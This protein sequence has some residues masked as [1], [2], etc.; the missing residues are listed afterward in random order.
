M[1]AFLL[2]L[3]LCA[4]ASA[5]LAYP[6]PPATN[7]RL[8]ALFSDHMVLQRDAPIVV[9]GWADPGGTVRVTLGTQTTETTVD[10]EGDWHTELPA[11]PAGGPYRLT[12]A[13]AE[14]TTFQDVMVG[15]VWVASG[16]SN[17]E[18]PVSQSNDAEREIAQAHY[19]QLRLFNSYWTCGAG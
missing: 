15:E 16:Q 5:A 1:P 19:P 10:A 14:E 9:W 4:P 17:M 18:W 7:V 8:P 13:G 12:I 6:G 3:L 2:V 11:M